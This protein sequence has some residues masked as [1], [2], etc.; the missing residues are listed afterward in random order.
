MNGFLLRAAFAG[1]LGVFVS[2]TLPSAPAKADI[3]YTLNTTNDFG[4]SGPGPYAQV[5]IHY[6]D[7]THATAEFTRLAGF[8]FGEIGLD[9]NASTFTVTGLTFILAP[10]CNQTPTYTVSYGTK[11]GG[12]GNFALDY[13]ANPNGF[14]S[15][16]IEAKFTLTNT[17]GTWADETKVL[18]NAVPEAAAHAFNVANGGES[19][20][21]SGG[22]SSCDDGC[23]I[24]PVIIDAP[25]P[26][27]LA[28]LGMGLLGLGAARRRR[29]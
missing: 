29:A 2:A 17:S 4:N 25:E 1:G 16:V 14:S 15:S 5:D 13:Q 8:T 9:V 6:I 18:T 20:F 24:T 11:V 19:F 3:I 23:V 27:S 26:A 22:P 21:T 7:T 12:I 28:V 10:S